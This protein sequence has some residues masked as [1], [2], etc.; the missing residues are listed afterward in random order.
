[1]KTC[2]QL[3][4]FSSDLVF[5]DRTLD[6]TPLARAVRGGLS[7]RFENAVRLVF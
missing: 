2:H 5:H 6:N 1:M 3:P 4:L 7:N